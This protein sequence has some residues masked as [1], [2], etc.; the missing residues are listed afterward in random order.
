MR[1]LREPWTLQEIEYF[2]VFNFKKIFANDFLRFLP[3]PAQ[4]TVSNFDQIFTN[5]FKAPAVLIE[6]SVYLGKKNFISAYLNIFYQCWYTRNMCGAVVDHAV[7]LSF[8]SRIAL[9][10]FILAT[11]LQHVQNGAAWLCRMAPFIHL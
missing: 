9:T 5:S 2:N 11:L 10:S 7:A 1:H 8:L 6:P 4:P 3:L